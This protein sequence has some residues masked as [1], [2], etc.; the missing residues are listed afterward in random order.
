MVTHAKDHQ[1]FQLVTVKLNL[2]RHNCLKFV[3]LLSWPMW[4]RPG[5]R[6]AADWSRITSALSAG[7]MHNK[8]QTCAETCQPYPLPTYSNE[9]V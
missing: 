5:W 7:H 8:L 1:P 3:S 9:P 6:Q 4:T 2:D